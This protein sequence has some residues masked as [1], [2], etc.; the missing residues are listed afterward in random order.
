MA[1]RILEPDE[2]AAL[3]TIAGRVL[4]RH[5]QTSDPTEVHE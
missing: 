1:L 3:R 4:H 5:Q 2:R